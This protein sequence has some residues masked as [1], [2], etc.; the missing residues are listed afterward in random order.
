[1][2]WADSYVWQRHFEEFSLGFPHS[3][4]TLGICFKQPTA[5]R[6]RMGKV[7]GH[8]LVLGRA[9]A[10]V[11]YNMVCMVDLGPHAGHPVFNLFQQ[12]AERNTRQKDRN[13]SATWK[14]SMRMLP[15]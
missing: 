13:F 14:L 1:V 8:P 11:F 6:H 2:I 5:A 12:F 9:M 15:G 3:G 10:K 4:R 7:P